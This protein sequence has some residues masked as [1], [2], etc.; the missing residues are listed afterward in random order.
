MMNPGKYL[1]GAE[2]FVQDNS[3]HI[4]TALGCVGVIS[5]AVLAGQA[6]FKA[7]DILEEEMAEAR[8]QGHDVRF[9]EDIPTKRVV[10]L[11]WKLYAPAVGVGATTVGCVV[12]ANRIGTRRAAA[13]ATA[14]AL[15][16]KAWQEYKEK[17]V[18]KFGEKK[19]QEVR[20]EVAQ[21]RVNRASEGR[22]IVLVTDSSKVLCHDAFSN[23]YFHSDME[24]LRKAQ[25]DINAQILHSDY[26]TV[27]DFYDYVNAEGLDHTS[28][29]GELGWN[30][31]K[32]LEIEFSSVLYKDKTPCISI[33]FAR[34]PIREPW[35]FC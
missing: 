18:E 34:V 33:N 6:T 8:A 1:R 14:Y 32:L 13:L 12:M 16:D 5:T 35:R 9:R 7:V 25:N 11:T 15:S 10:E 17:V 27:S 21:D 24:T 22:D 29:S 19:E 2:K 20:D 28:V 31:D 3:P 26:A 23:Q 30:T 4:L